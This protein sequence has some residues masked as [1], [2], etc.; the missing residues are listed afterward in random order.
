MVVRI[1]LKRSECR[2]STPW[3]YL[4][5]CRF[6]RSEAIM[7]IT[8]HSQWRYDCPW[9]YF[10]F[11]GLIYATV[12]K[13]RFRFPILKLT[14]GWYCLIFF[15]ILI[16]KCTF[17]STKTHNSRGLSSG[18]AIEAVISDR[19]FARIEESQYWYASRMLILCTI[20]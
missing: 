10:F 3:Y 1:M 13:V 14:V 15:K 20:F 17:P 5:R 4:F 11:I 9:V 6:W 7:P 19:R 18:W 16:E 12:V 8:L 2:R